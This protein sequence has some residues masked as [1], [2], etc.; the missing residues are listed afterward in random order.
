MPITLRIALFAGLLALLSNL[1]V[2]GFITFRTHDEMSSNRYRQLQEQGE[3][4]ADVNRSG[5]LP[6]L[7]NAVLDPDLQNDP[8]AVVAIVDNNGNP[9]VGSLQSRPDWREPLHEGYLTTKV[10][11]HGDPVAREASVRLFRA[12]PQHWLLTG[13]LTGDEMAVR[14]ILERSLLI[15]LAI[16]VLLG[17]LTGGLLAQFVER[18]VRDIVGITSAFGA[19]DFARRLPV[20]AKGGDAFAGLS[21]QINQMLDRIATLMEELRMLTDSLAHDLRSPVSRLRSAADAA[22]SA[23]DEQE[24]DLLLGN[25][26]AQADSLMRV[27]TT[28]LEIGR[29]ES[30]T[31]RSQFTR[32][33]PDELGREL[34]EMYEPVAEEQ[35]VTL[36]FGSAAHP[37]TVFGHRQLLAQA[38][39]NLIEN[40]L[41]Y[42][43]SGGEIRV[44]I[45]ADEDTLRL[46]VA[47]RGPGIPAERREEARRRFGRLDPSRSRQGA[48]LGLPLVQAIAHLHDGEL[49]LRDNRPGLSAELELPLDPPAEATA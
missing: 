45:A 13:R 16:A 37:A 2:I 10:R 47:D 24:R 49:V 23:T 46:G 32:F 29:S 35:G 41:N 20:Q 15:G 28:V 11:K 26:I 31:A 8:Q 43:A 39:S 6:A 9:L 4:L 7:R 40:S 1:A 36:S 44:F 22:V 19:G 42:G 30:R 3:A 12:D 14:E 27:L 38:L 17:L 18:R 48:G 21:R 5:G 25:V 34:V 33:D